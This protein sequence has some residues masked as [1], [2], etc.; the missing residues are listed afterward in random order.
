M[1]NYNM[2]NS[3]KDNKNNESKGCYFCA[4]N[5]FDIDYKDIRT[6]HRFI[7]IYKKNQFYY[8]KNLGISKKTLWIPILTFEG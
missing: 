7:N 1:K 4:N 8:Y 6:I 2:K 5:I 3:K